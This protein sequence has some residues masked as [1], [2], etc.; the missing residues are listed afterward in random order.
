VTAVR[1]QWRSRTKILGALTLLLV[2]IDIVLGRLAHGG[3]GALALV[4]L[5][6]PALGLVI[7]R[8]QPAN[9]IGLLLLGFGAGLSFYADAGTYAVLDY[10]VHH[11]RLPLGVPAVLLASEL[12]IGIFLTLPVV[13]LLFPDGQLSRRW[14]MTLRAYVAVSVAIVAILVGSTAA[15]VAGTPIVINGKGQLGDN[16]FPSGA[17]AI[18]FLLLLGTVPVFWVLFVARQATSW[19]QATN[20]RKEQ[21]KWLTAGGVLTVCGFASTFA[22]A[23]FSGPAVTVGVAVSL[24][25]G[26]FSLPVGISVGILKFRLYDIDRL[27]SRTLS[28]A[29]V[30]GLIIGLYVGVITLTTGAFHL[31]SPLAVAASTLAAA[32]V[33]TPLRV[34]T[35]HVVDRR[36]NRARY[37]ADDTVAA[38]AQQLR[39]A[40]DLDSVRLDLF[41]VV[42]RTLEPSH[43]SVWLPRVEPVVTSGVDA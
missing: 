14:Q 27:I 21:L 26:L 19:R 43:L 23:Q 17:L 22:F 8:R 42:Q 6:V 4:A 12:W 35:Q 36:F 5:A 38:F 41:A 32:A 24:T 7:L 20:E 30:T 28:Y 13:I 33:F 15:R 31:S 3:G 18:P 16:Q 34:R 39:V 37:D 9:S 1:P 2:V 40:V 29:V 25:L 10:H 11:G